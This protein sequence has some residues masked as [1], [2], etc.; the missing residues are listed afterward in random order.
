MATP[1]GLRAQLAADRAA[2]A[3][4]VSPGPKK[5]A[6]GRSTSGTPVPRRRTT[7]AVAPR[8]VVPAP[9]GTSSTPS[10]SKAKSGRKVAVMASTPTNKT[11][12]LALAST[13]HEQLQR[14]ALEFRL[15]AQA[16]TPGQL[17]VMTGHV[18]D[19]LKPFLPEYFGEAALSV[20]VVPVANGTMPAPPVVPAG[21]RGEQ[22]KQ[23]G[24]LL[25]YKKDGMVTLYKGDS[26]LVSVPEDGY[27]KNTAYKAV[28]KKATGKSAGGWFTF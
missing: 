20:S 15:A 3:K 25:G 26:V 9:A 23:E 28:L 10:A 6:T 19:D 16:A 1:T 5:A 4:A 12:W 27:E 14:H 11:A 21:N 22:F 17:E 18:P 2:A 7:K 13:G 24:D 8:K